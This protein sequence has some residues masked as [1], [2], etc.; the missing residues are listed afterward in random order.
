[1]FSPKKYFVIIESFWC[2]N[3]HPYLLFC[4]PFIPHS[5]ELLPVTAAVCGQYLVRS[6]TLLLYVIKADI[7]PFPY[8][9]GLSHEIEMGYKNC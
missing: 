4:Q 9:K 1:L 7:Q 6:K 3:P 5:L 2:P 8:L